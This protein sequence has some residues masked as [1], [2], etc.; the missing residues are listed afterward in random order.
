[1]S[2]FKSGDAKEVKEVL[3]VVSSEIPKLL[4]AIS[5]AMY[6]KEN[7]ENLGRSVAQ[8]YKQMK[9]AGMDEEQAFELTEK[10]MQ[11]FS[12]GGMI[13]QVLQGGVN[14]GDRT[15]INSDI[16]RKI[17]KKIAREL[18]DEDEEEDDEEDEEDEDEKE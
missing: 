18:D 9:D 4:E 8:F 7:A 11:N 1:M 16:K 14:I 12:M 13:G 17:R 5:N 15:D 6:T 3:E 2:D 10:F